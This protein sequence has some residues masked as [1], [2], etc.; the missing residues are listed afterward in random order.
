M[1]CLHKYK[2]SSS[3]RLQQWEGK[4]KKERHWVANLV[5]FLSK[6]QKIKNLFYQTGPSL[7]SQQ[8]KVSSNSSEKVGPQVMNN[9][10]RW[11][12]LTRP[13]APHV[14]VR[15]TVHLPTLVWLQQEEK[16][17][18]ETREDPPI[19]RFVRGTSPAPGPNNIIL[20]Y[21]TH[22]LYGKFQNT[23]SYF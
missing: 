13:T 9:P 15:A 16:E 3:W 8:P 12:H 5:I 21:F 23:P 6:N 20:Y 4:K 10:T 1:V 11:D 17:K 2:H 22:Y 7:L 19:F 18:L 14:E